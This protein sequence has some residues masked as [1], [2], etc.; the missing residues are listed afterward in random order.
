MTS[1]YKDLCENKF[2]DGELGYLP[3]LSKVQKFKLKKQHPDLPTIFLDGVD[4]E[5]VR[6]TL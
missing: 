4:G 6:V 1:L 2:P 5:H 3:E